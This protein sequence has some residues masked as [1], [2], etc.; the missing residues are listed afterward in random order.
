[1]SDPTNILSDEELT[2]I[3][4][5]NS[6]EVSEMPK[7]KQPPKAPWWADQAELKPDTRGIDADP[8]GTRTLHKSTNIASKE[9]RD[10]AVNQQSRFGKLKNM[11]KSNMPVAKQAGKKVLGAG[12]GLAGL[13]MQEGLGPQSGSDDEIIEDPSQP[14]EVRKAAM[15]RMKNKYLKPQ[16][17]NE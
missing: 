3:L 12:L 10:W 11:L 14:I 2:D 7:K 8:S 15:L 5:S 4:S 6:S 17:E 9:A 1:M 16:E 13:L